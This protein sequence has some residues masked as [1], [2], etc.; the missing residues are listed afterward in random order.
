MNMISMRIHSRKSEENNSGK[1]HISQFSQTNP[2]DTAVVLD[3]RL[4]SKKS[5][6]HANK[7]KK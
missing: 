7:G 1:S 3:F 6:C 5:V 2:I 4:G